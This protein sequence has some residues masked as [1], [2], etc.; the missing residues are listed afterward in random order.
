MLRRSTFRCPGR[1]GLLGCFC[2]D[3]L[4]RPAN[5]C[6]EFAGRQD[7]RVGQ[8]HPLVAAH[9][10]S[11]G[12]AFDLQ[13]FVKCFRCTFKG[14][15]RESAVREDHASKDPAADFKA[16]VV[17][18]RHILGRVGEGQAESADPFD[19]GH[20]GDDSAAALLCGDAALPR[21]GGAE[22]RHHARS[23]RRRIFDRWLFN[24]GRLAVGEGEA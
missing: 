4:I 12:N 8:H 13:Q 18:P 20:V 14:D 2:H 9:V 5:E 3:Q 15:A 16:K 1:L 24:Q 21:P 6:F 23:F 19:V 10:R 11:G 22:P 17:G 7:I